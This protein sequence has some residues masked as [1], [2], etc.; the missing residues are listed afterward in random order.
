MKMNKRLIGSMRVEEKKQLKG[1][2]ERGKEILRTWNKETLIEASIN[3]MTEEQLRFF[4]EDEDD[5]EPKEEF[6]FR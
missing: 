5:G 1:L 6:V 2:M 4:V 3:E